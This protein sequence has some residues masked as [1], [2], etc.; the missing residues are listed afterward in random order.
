VSLPPHHDPEKL[1]QAAF[2]PE[3]PIVD[4][5]RAHGRRAYDKTWWWVRMVKE[6]GFP[7]V[8]AWW[9]A[10]RLMPSLDALKAAVDRDTRV[11]AAL[12]CKL[13]PND[14]VRNLSQEPP[15]APTPSE[16]P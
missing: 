1:I 12:I 2:S 13:D 5:P 14:C 6:V 16:T 10:S 4:G 3:G 7:I 15:A 11:T 8:A 9:L